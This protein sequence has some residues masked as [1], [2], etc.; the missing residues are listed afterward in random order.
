MIGPIREVGCVGTVTYGVSRG[1]RLAS[2]ALAGTSA[3][4]ELGVLCG[5]GDRTTVCMGVIDRQSST[6]VR[7][8]GGQQP[9]P[10][11]RR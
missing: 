5:V 2:N 9:A 8:R 7:L 6:P 3:L 10:W 11:R 4:V 1:P